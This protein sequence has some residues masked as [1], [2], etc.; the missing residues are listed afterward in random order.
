MRKLGHPSL[1]WWSLRTLRVPWSLVTKDVQMIL[2]W[3]QCCRYFR[4]YLHTLGNCKVHFVTQ[5]TIL[6]PNLRKQGQSPSLAPVW[7]HDADVISLL[8]TRM[9]DTRARDILSECLVTGSL[10]LV[11]L[12]FRPLVD[13]C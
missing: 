11:F 10:E 12:F 1:L 5:Q 7:Q 3:D 6:I 2:S 4:T 8:Y 9:H 13:V